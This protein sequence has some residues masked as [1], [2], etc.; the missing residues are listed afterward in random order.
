MAVVC[1]ATIESSSGSATEAPTPCR[2]VRRDRCF[3]VMNIPAPGLTGRL[4]AAS[5]YAYDPAGDFVR[6]WN[7]GVL[8]TPSTSDEKRYRSFIAPRVTARTDGMSS[9]RIARPTA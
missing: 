3:F 7:C 6:I 4:E 5:T 8:T 9:G 2:N 1:A